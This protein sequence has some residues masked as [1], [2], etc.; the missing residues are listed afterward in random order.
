[1]SLSIDQISHRRYLK[2]STWQKIRTTALDH[3]GKICNKCGE[4]AN[5][6]HHLYYP[7]VQG[8]ETIE[9]LEVLCRDCHEA[10]HGIQRGNGCS[11]VVH[12][13]SLYNYLTEK[14]KKIISEKLNVPICLVFMCDSLDGKR[15]RNMAVKMLNV[16]GYYGIEKKYEDEKYLTLEES[17]ARQSKEKRKEAKKRKAWE[18]LLLNS[19]PRLRGKLTKK[20]EK[21]YSSEA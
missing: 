1:M 6:V 12:I 2:S 7:E 15:A 8:E 17:R 10:I 14:H 9:S 21:V 11:E 13:Q 4:Y 18:K 3:Y 5:D 19:D 20:N 16:G